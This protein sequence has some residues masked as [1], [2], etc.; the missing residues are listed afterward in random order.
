MTEIYDSPEQCVSLL[1]AT[2]QAK[3][4]D[5]RVNEETKLPVSV[6]VLRGVIEE[7]HV[8]NR[9]I[10]SLQ[11]HLRRETRQVSRADFQMQDKF[12]SEPYKPDTGNC[13]PACIATVLG[14][15]LEEV[16]H[17]YSVC[18]NIDNANATM[19][20]FLGNRGYHLAYYPVEVVQNGIREGWF[21]TGGQGDVVVVLVTGKSPRFNGLHV[22]VGTLDPNAPGY[23]TMLHDPHPD[24]AGL[25]EVTG[26]EVLSKTI[27]TRL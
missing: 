24:G 27:R 18:A 11:E 20:E 23:W 7:V 21:Y 9:S 8:L 19:A 5:K 3:Q 10:D 16:P 13:F 12:G 6:G 17:V 26:F 4:K 22:V 14:I 2:L 15:K 1:A 25:T